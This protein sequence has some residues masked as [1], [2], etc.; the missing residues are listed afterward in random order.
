MV[1]SILLRGFDQQMAELVGDGLSRH[2]VKFIRGYVPSA[3]ERLEAGQPGKLRVKAR[4]TA[5]GD[6]ISDE[7]DTVSLARAS[8][9]F[10]VVFRPI[11]SQITT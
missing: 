9:E 7:Y 11:R 10:I 8:V 1:R 5:G 6:E 4:P 2:H 3:V